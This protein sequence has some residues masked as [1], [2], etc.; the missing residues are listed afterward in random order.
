MKRML[1]LLIC[2]TMVFSANSVNAEMKSSKKKGIGALSVK[3]PYLHYNNYFGYVSKEH[4]PDGKY[5]K[6]DAY[7]LYF[8]VPA[9][10]DEIGV[11]MY[12]PANKNP[13][14]KDFKHPKF[15][16]LFSRNSKKFFDTYIILNKMDIYDPAKIK[17]GGTAISKL[18]KNDDSREMPKNPGGRRY[19]SL[20]RHTSI[21]NDPLKALT[22]GVY[23]I[24]LTSFR[25]R[26]EGSFIATIG[27]NIPGVKIA[28]SLDELHKMVNK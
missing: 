14:G 3:L 18:I 23:R 27:T 24:T 19:N 5:N 7:Y 11:C 6:K 20:L 21:K 28:A 2:A 8:W 9:V 15:D 22:R 17:N 13:N 1:Y 12:S 10:I 16:K 26:V 25:T 4:K